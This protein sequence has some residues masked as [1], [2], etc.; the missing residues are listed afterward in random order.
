MRASGLSLKPTELDSALEEI[1]ERKESAEVSQN[2][3]TEQARQVVQQQKETAELMRK[4]GHGKVVTD[5]SQ[6]GEKEEE[7]FRNK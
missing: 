2:N 3:S 5:T 6:G 1:V 4:R 7:K